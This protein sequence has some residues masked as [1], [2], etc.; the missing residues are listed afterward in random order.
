MQRVFVFVFVALCA[1]AMLPLACA[2]GQASLEEGE[3]ADA[4]TDASDVATGESDVSSG[5]SHDAGAL[6]E[7]ATRPDAGPGADATTTMDAHDDITS[8]GSDAS[9]M[10]APDVGVMDATGMDAAEDQGNDSGPGLPDAGGGGTCTADQW[11]VSASIAAANNPASYAIDGLSPTRWSTG[12]NQQVGQYFQ[13]DFGGLVQ[14]SQIVFDNS[15]GP[16]EHGDYPR[17]LQVFGSTDGTSFADML[18]NQTFST[19]PGAV[20][21]IPFAATSVRALRMTL[22]AGDPTAWWSIHELGVMCNG[23]SAR[24]TTTA[25]TCQSPGWSSSVGLSNTGWTATASSTSSGDSLAGAFD[26]NATTRWS[27]ATQAG[28]E[29]FQ[30]DLGQSTTISEVDLYLLSGNTSDYPSAYRLDLSSDNQT[31]TTAATGSGAA[32]TTA[33]CFP[34]QSARYLRIAQIGTGYMSWWSIYELAVLP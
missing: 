28:G 17:G 33:I 1:A 4:S 3:P 6:S 13:V 22:T 14:A 23:S 15:F 34:R 27:E 18:A 10:D 32:P 21:T 7:A 30:L 24:G 29:W 26:G 11:Q 19:D 12:V 16:T 25:G 2:N 20:V 8:D 5:P 31:F 9:V